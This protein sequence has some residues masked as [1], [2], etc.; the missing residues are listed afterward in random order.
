MFGMMMVISFKKS[1]GI[2]SAGEIDV[3]EELLHGE[4]HFSEALE[5][6][7]LQAVGVIVTAA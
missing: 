3:V 7:G 5:D 2:S 6:D 4:Q 1:F